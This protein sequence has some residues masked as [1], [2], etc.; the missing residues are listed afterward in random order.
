MYTYHIAQ[1][2]MVENFDEF[3]EWLAI[4]QSFPYQPLSLNVFPLKSTINSSQSFTRQTSV[5]D[6]F[7][8]VFPCQTFA[9]Y[10][11]SYT[12]MYTYP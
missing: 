9:L 1:S 3:D 7:V 10:D 6:S 12:H 4:C 5:N 8:K 2:L 11:I